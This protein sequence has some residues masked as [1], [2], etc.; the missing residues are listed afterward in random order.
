MNTFATLSGK[1]GRMSHAQAP[2][3][4]GRV[5]QDGTV[6]VRT[7][8][9]ERSVG[10]VPD[11]TS[12]EALEFFVRRYHA[13]ETEV[14][15]LESRVTSG[16]ASPEEARSAAS[17]LVTSIREANAVGDLE[18][19]AARVEALSPTIDAKAETRRE[20]R[21]EAKARAK[22]AKEEMVAQAEAIA[23]GNDW[24][25]GTGKFRDLL[26][27]WRRLPRIDKT[28]DDELWH[29]FSGARTAFTRRRKQHIAEQNHVRER[30]RAIK[31]QIIEEARP[32]AESTAWGETSRQFRDLMNRWKA[33]G[34][35]PRDVDDKLWKEFRAIQ[36]T[37]FGARTAAQSQQDEEYRGNQQVKEQL[38]DEAEKDILP[39]TDIEQAKA[40]L[41]AFLEKF[42]EVGRVPRDAMKRIDARVRDLEHHVHSAEEAE[43]KRTDPQAR[44]RARATVDMFSA[45]IS[46][47]NAQAEK[48]EAAGRT[49]DA[50][51]ARESIKTYQAWL[52]EAQKALDEFSA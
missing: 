50:E 31:E 41:R 22:A 12:E 37:F 25:G 21:A 28:T 16:T 42:N 23:A 49:K 44:E 4:F 11:S 5:D 35:A 26:E 51:K 14:S 17:K 48:A 8:D 3:S 47:L 24:R 30:A 19:L 1:M 45:Q 6:Y 52:D 32:L 38:L 40:K 27:Q 2:Q 20:E 36:D 13:L 15:L 39:V 33:A 9:G 34:P 46:K 10:Q 29:R 18:S 43:W 7:S